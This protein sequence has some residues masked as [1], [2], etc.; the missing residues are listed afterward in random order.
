MSLVPS[1]R[2]P[3]HRRGKPASKLLI[4]LVTMSLAIATLGLG[5]TARKQSPQPTASREYPTSQNVVPTPQPA[6]PYTPSQGLPQPAPSSA[7]HAPFTPEQLKARVAQVIAERTKADQAK[8]AWVAEQVRLAGGLQGMVEKQRQMIADRL[9][10]LEHDNPSS[11]E[12]PRLRKRLQFFTFPPRVDTCLNGRPQLFDA[13]GLTLQYPG[14]QIDNPPIQGGQYYLLTG[15]NFGATPG[16]VSIT[17]SNGQ[18]VGFATVFGSPAGL[19]WG[20]TSIIG[21]VIY[22]GG[23]WISRRTWLSP[24]RMASRVPLSQFNSWPPAISYTFYQTQRGFL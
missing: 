14:L 5:C 17:L 19:L 21:Y 16:S 23:S 24:I 4:G 18:I 22:L 12:I 1:H 9:S 6:K 10:Q 13:Y 15:C 11:A 7:F 8:T 20:D 3:A 2:T